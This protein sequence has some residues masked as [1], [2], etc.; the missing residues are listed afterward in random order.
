[1]VTLSDP[2]DWFHRARR[3]TD[4]PA[5]SDWLKNALLTAINRDPMDAAN[6]ADELRT[7]LRKRAKAT[8]GRV[9]KTSPR[10]SSQTQS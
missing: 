9:S 5:A 7:I 3:V 8:K 2:N 1:M 6:D 4:D 10:S